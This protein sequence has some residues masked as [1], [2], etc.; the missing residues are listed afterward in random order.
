MR[1][2]KLASH[3][4]CQ[5]A[6]KFFS[7]LVNLKFVIGVNKLNMQQRENKKATYLEGTYSIGVILLAYP[8]VSVLVFFSSGCPSP[9]SWKIG[10]GCVLL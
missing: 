7:E 2:P 9:G 5:Y 1:R 4:H 6:G 3:G 10:F 8:K